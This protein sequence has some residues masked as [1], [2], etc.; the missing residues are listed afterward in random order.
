MS[1]TIEDAAHELADEIKR[2]EF[3]ELICHSDADGITAGAIMATALYRAG[4]RFRIRA[5]SRIET[6]SLPDSSILLCDL[7]SGLSDLPES[8][9]VIDHHN[10]LFEGP[11]H[12]NP[13]LHNI[14]G[15][16]ELSGAGAAYIVANALG[17]NRD[18][19]G[20]V[21][22]GILGDEQEMVGKNKEIC[23]EA[24]AT[25]IIEHGHG[26]CL[27][28]RTFE[29]KILWSTK[30]YFTGYSGDED[31]IMSL[32]AKASKRKEEK[33]S[34]KD[35]SLETTLVS[36]LLVM[37][38]IPYAGYDQICGLY[39]DTYTLTRE[40]VADAY[41]MSILLD[42]CAKSGASGEA[43][44]VAM[45]APMD[46]DIAFKAA[47][48]YRMRIITEMNKLHAECSAKTGGETL[49][50]FQTD[51][52]PL[53][54]D[55][56]DAIWNSYPRQGSIAVLGP[57][58]ENQIRVSFRDAGTKGVNLGICAN[59]L[60]KKYHGFGGG[61]LTRAGAT[62]PADEIDAFMTDMREVFA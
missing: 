6:D 40:N 2:H 34:N 38:A 62:I 55:I 47:H 10:P 20:L 57:I 42:A 9:M 1:T 45:R 53:V 60:A 25:G 21:I 18:L 43:L 22:V 56:A 14:N 44:A 37:C 23:Q 35:K 41:T 61:H 48:S 19:C 49:S 36:S 54:S 29:E 7:G 8:A 58:H 27:G 15:D 28:G 5:K 11:F 12:V 31:A 30:P 3:I 39:G 46:P 33:H 52:F 4:V 26:L 59:E 24:I 32:F 13:R 16:T 51:E 50:V 17:D